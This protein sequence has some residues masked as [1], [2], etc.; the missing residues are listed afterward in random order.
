MKYRL[1][2]EAVVQELM[3]EDWEGRSHGER[4]KLHDEIT[5]LGAD[6]VKILKPRHL[7]KTEIRD[8]PKHVTDRRQQF[9]DLGAEERGED[10]PVADKGDGFNEYSDVADDWDSYNDNSDIVRLRNLN[11]TPMSQYAQL[12][13]EIDLLHATNKLDFMSDNASLNRLFDL[14]AMGKVGRAYAAK[15]LQY[16]TG[17]SG[18]PFDRDA[19][20]P[21][22]FSP[23]TEKRKM[24]LKFEW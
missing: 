8:L 10:V 11:N 14:A 18:G 24:G 17:K 2:K 22:A 13:D 16:V 5:E 23:S 19:F 15:L 9:A 21:N 3:N 1:L 12:K 20:T 4:K 7:T 6:D